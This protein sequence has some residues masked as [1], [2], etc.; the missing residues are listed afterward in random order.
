VVL[1]MVA[2]TNGLCG[3]LVHAGAALTRLYLWQEF[4]DSHCIMAVKKCHH[5][6]CRNAF[7]G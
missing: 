4:A 2:V 1:E 6:M 3:A 5:A 7:D